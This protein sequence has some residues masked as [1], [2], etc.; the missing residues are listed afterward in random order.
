M[1][2]NVFVGPSSLQGVVTVPPSKSIAHRLLIAASLAVENGSGVKLVQGVDEG[3]S[4]DLAAT[5]RSIRALLDQDSEPVLLD[6]GESASTLRF[7]VPIAAALGK[8]VLFTGEATLS[9]RPLRE[10]G[11]IMAGKGVDLNFPAQGCLPLKLRG[12]LVGSTYYVPGSV[13]SQYV[14]GLLFALPLLTGNSEIWL[15]SPLESEPYAAITESVLEQFGIVVDRIIAD[16]GELKGWLVPGNQRYCLP[17]ESLTV[18][19]DYSQAA[20]WLVARYLGHSVEVRGLNPDSVQGDRVILELLAR[21][22]PESDRE[23]EIDVSQV[24]DLVPPLAVAACCRVGRTVLSG[25]GRLRLKESDRLHALAVELRKLGAAVEEGAE[26]LI[27]TGGK[28]IMGG[29]ADSHGDHRIAMALAIVALQTEDGVLIEG[30]EAVRK[31]YP[32]FFS[33]L[34]RLGGAVRGIDLG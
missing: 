30:A 33:E 10:Y 2:N 4:E 12:Q 23:I 21:L 9:R 11:E 13:S 24:P 6:C 27:I 17:A 8:T 14:T 20:F 34:K 26:Q 22:R 7:L 19:G 29:T 1:V 5:I 28:P 32:H 3:T 25:A 18:E 31:S 16:G 15:T